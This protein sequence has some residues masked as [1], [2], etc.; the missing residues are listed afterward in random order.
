MFI[1]FGNFCLA[2]EREKNNNRHNGKEMWRDATFGTNTKQKVAI[3]LG[4]LSDI[5][6]RSRTTKWIFFD[7]IIILTILTY[8]VFLCW[9]CTPP[10][11]RQILINTPLGWFQY[12]TSCDV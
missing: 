11:S 1:Y 6:R 10:E 7:I 8:E 2:H 4:M 12:F 5:R 3:L 9:G